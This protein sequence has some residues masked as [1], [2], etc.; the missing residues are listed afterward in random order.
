MK[1]N[2]IHND[3][4]CELGDE[5]PRWRVVE[6][7]PLEQCIKLFDREN[8][9]EVIKPMA[10]INNDIV[11]GKLVLH[12]KNTPKLSIAAH[13]DPELDKSI[14]RALASVKVIEKLQRKHGVSFA[15]AYKIAKLEGANV[16]E[17]RAPLPS[18]PS[19]YRYAKAKRNDIPPLLG[20]L[21]KGNRVPVSYTHLTLPTNR[22]V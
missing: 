15:G 5:K 17:D 2:L 6:S 22:E 7:L 18:L 21:N 10:G 3:E 1:R 8:Q 12:R 20:N 11:S 9:I 13:D 19:L 4:L 14:Q 16:P